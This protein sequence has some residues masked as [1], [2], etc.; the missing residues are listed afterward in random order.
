[1][2]IK[3]RTY[4]ESLFE[5]LMDPKEAIAYLNAAVIDEDP[6]IFL[7]ALQDVLTAQN[8]RV[9]KN[10]RV[11][12]QTTYDAI[13]QDKK[14]KINIDHEYRELLISELILAATAKDESAVRK[15]AKA[16][17]KPISV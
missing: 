11:I 8:M 15:L 10:Y 9:K 5:A 14:R 2:K 4:E 1:M 3:Y 16:I 7:L 13:A 12:T 6:R 17:K